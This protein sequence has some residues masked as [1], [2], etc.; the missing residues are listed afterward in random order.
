MACEI[1]VKRLDVEPNRRI[2]VTSDIHGH[3]VH[4]KHVLKKAAFSQDD[5][6]V[7]AGDM[8][9]KGP[10][11]LNTL[12]Y[13]MDLYGAGN[14]VVLAGNVDLSRVRTFDRL[15][16][17]NAGDF[18]DYLERM[19][20]WKGTSFFDEMMRE[21]GLTAGRP[22][23]LT[24]CKEVLASRFRRELD[25]I[26]SLP[27]ILETQN[28]L[29]V[30]A[31]LPGKNLSLLQTKRL[32]D[33][34]AVKNFLSTN[35]RFDKTVVV[36]HWPVTLYGEAIA[37]ANPII[38]RE[39]RIVSIDGGCG[40]K[41]DGQLNLLIIPAP[42]CGIGEISHVSYD[43]FETFAAL[44]PQAAS[45][46]SINIHWGDNRIRPLEKQG[47]FTYAEHIRTGYRLWIHNA[48]LYDGGGACDDYTDYVLPVAA[49]DELALVRATSRGY[50]VKKNGVTG[51]YSGE[52]KPTAAP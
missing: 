17:E 27:T 49:G 48:Y 34:L 41:A 8:I 51:W 44:T 18:W 40:L 14:V 25:F 4:L 29:F 3:L 45:E 39:K 22:A 42:A 1:T 50:L 36:G 52:L 15:N 13:I 20:R 11:G 5:L 19:R 12:R 7:V 31:G 28:F 46:R 32:D 23:E 38:D 2:L 10:E 9:E 47:D 30:H 33:V 26:R 6:L 43:G 21:S 35:V 24:A 16:E 37:Q